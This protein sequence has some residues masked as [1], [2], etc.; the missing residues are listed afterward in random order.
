[1]RKTPE[2][3]LSGCLGGPGS[4]SATPDQVEAARRYCEFQDAYPDATGC[5]WKRCVKARLPS[6]PE[7]GPLH[8]Y[9][10]TPCHDC[11]GKG[12]ERLGFIGTFSEGK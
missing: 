9:V 7:P 1:V 10:E 8:P 5:F 11:P 4:P 12:R 3:G 2:E 6:L